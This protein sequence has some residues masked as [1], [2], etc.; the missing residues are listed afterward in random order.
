MKVT[1]VI[2]AYNEEKTVGE[3]V[4]RALKHVDEVVVV[5]DGSTDRT[6]EVAEKAGAKVVRHRENKGAYEAMRTGFKHAAGEIVVTLGADG[7][8]LP[9]EIPLLVE[10]ILRG[11]ADLVVGRRK[12]IP[13]F[14]EKVIL[15]LTN[16]AVKC[17]DASSGFMAIR[18]SILDRMKLRGSCH[19]GTF[20]IEAKRLGARVKEVPIT[21]L[22]R[23]YGKRRIKTRHVKQT[24]YVLLELLLYFA[25][26]LF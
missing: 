4:E 1:A 20:L 13:Y 23:R 7:Q 21:I 22:P 26:K 15:K 6:A 24:F 11:E 2:P 3:V 12:E 17:S 8:N 16:L 5:D 14:S 10:P 18:K 25:K 9:E 19:C